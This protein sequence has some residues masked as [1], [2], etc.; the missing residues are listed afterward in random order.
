MQSKPVIRVEQDQRSCG[1]LEVRADDAVVEALE[2]S[3]AKSQGFLLDSKTRKA[4][5]NYA[6]DAATQYFESLGYVVEDHSKDHPYD[7]RCTGKE[8]VLYV[9]VKGTQTNG[10]GIILTAGEVEFGRRHKGQIALFLLHSISVSEG[11]KVLANGRK[12][13]IVPWDVDQGCLKPV[14]FMYA[15]PSAEPRM[16]SRPIL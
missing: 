10:D 6:M 16:P 9:E 7:L 4:L 5:E 3:H 13:M 2:K 11:R 12:R 8:G 15:L 1:S 14:S